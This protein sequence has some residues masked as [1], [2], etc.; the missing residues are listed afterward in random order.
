M[1]LKNSMKFAS[2]LALAAFCVAVAVTSCKKNDDDEDALP[3]MTGQLTFDLPLY[4]LVGETYSLT[5]NSVVTPTSGVT[6]CWYSA[7]LIDTI[8]GQSA[9]ITIPDSLATF[10]VQYIAKCSGYYNQSVSNNITV[11]KPGRNGS[12]VG[13]P[14]AKDSILDARENRWYHV[15][16]I[17]NLRWFTENLNYEGAGVPYGNARA[18]GTVFGRLYTWKEATGGESRTGLGNGPQGVCPEGWSVPTKEDWQDLAKAA[19]GVDNVEFFDDWK[20]VGDALAVSAT[21]N[22]SDIWPFSGVATP[23]NKLGWNALAT[24]YVTNN[25]NNFGMLFKYGFWWSS[26]EKDSNSAYYRY[27]FYNQTGCPVNHV[28]KDSFGVSV[29]CVKKIEL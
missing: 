13:L 19:L 27:I 3:S 29:R 26:S 6:Y 5:G 23:N 21:F 1:N 17:G 20:G 18:A 11:V 28:S 15:K 22:G 4:S 2:R 10:A 14:Q 25:G 12:I 9:T 24:G 16:E 7:G 8:K